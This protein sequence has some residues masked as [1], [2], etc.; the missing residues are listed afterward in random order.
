MRTGMGS[1]R[2]SARYAI[3]FEK[4]GGV[5]DRRLFTP[6]HVLAEIHSAT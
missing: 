1:G 6:L 3:E 5:P 2:R 4:S